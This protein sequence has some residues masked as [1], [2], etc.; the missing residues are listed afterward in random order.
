MLAYIF[1][2]SLQNRHLPSEIPFEITLSHVCGLWRGVALNTPNLW[3]RIQVYSLRSSDSLSNYLHR[4]GSRLPLDILID[5]YSF[6]KS[7]RL[8]S[9]KQLALVRALS[10]KLVSEIHR[11]RKL[12]L[13]CFYKSTATLI[14]SKLRQS[15]ALCLEQL[16]VN[17]DLPRHRATLNYPP[18]Q[19]ITIFEGGAPQLTYL[20]TDMPNVVPF[21]S[22]LWNLTTLHLHSFNEESQLT[23]ASFVEVLKAPRSLQYLSIQ[24][25]IQITSWPLHS[26]APEFE[27]TCLK[28]LR[29]LDDAMMAVRILLSM[30]APNMESLWLHIS[31]REFQ[32]FFDSSQMQTAVG[33]NK[34]RSLKYLTLPNHNFRTLGSFA[35]AF[36]TV[37]HFHALYPSFWNPKEMQQ[38]LKTKWA[39][40]DTVIF[41]RTR[42]NKT[43]AFYAGLQDVLV[44]RRGSG[45]PIKKMLVDSDL[46]NMLLKSAP[47]IIKQVDVDVIS[48]HNYHEIWW[49]K[50]DRLEQ[51][52]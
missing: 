28:A 35:T 37:T 46:F 18:V 14:L 20:A 7:T 44:H 43:E 52:L 50:V 26:T 29:L 42:E 9:K 22:A 39:L 33:Q 36:P 10:N 23:Y 34:F 13:F 12:S 38:T 30:S 19:K 24:G 16:I 15:S 40:L 51:D 48:P 8:M 3:T 2:L 5:T 1:S 21:T 32:S 25:R 47:K 31:P 41:S 11:I 45:H 27:L 17:H 6:E 49:N 4:S